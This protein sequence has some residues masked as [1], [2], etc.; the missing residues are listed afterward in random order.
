[1]DT[2]KKR[3]RPLVQ[4]FLAELKLWRSALRLYAQS[5]AN[6]AKK[7]WKNYKTKSARRRQKFLDKKLVALSRGLYFPGFKNILAL[8]RILNKF[9]HRLLEILGAI[10]LISAVLLVTQ[11]WLRVTVEEAGT[12]G[13]YREGL[14]GN[15]RFL[16]PIYLAGNQTDHDISRLL[17]SSLLKTDASGNL[18]QDLAEEV[19]L[20]DGGKKYKITIRKNALFHDGTALGAQDVI[21]TL[22]YIKN[23]EYK[24]PLRPL[25]GG[26][27]AQKLDDYTLTLTLETPNPAFGAFLTF[28][29][30]PEHLWK[31]IKPAET[32][33]AILN[34]KP[35]GSGPYKF[36]SL[37]KDQ[38]GLVRSITVEAFNQY[39]GK[40]PKISLIT[41][42]FFPDEE[43]AIQS[44]KNKEIEALAFFSAEVPRETKRRTD[45]KI[46]RPQTFSYSAFFFNNS[47]SHTGFPEV[48]RALSLAL[49][50]EA[51]YREVIKGSGRLMTG[52]IPPEL[53]S[54]YTEQIPETNL[55][56]ANKILE[57]SGWEQGGEGARI[58]KT[59]PASKKDRGGETLLEI[60]LVTTDDSK[61]MRIAEIAAKSWENIGIKTNLEIVPRGAIVEFLR[62][63][64]YDVLLYGQALAED[65][66]LYPFWHSSGINF[67]GLNLAMFSSREADS[68]LEK[69]RLETDLRNKLPYYRELNKIFQR[70]VP[71]IF[72]WSPRSA[73]VI[74]TKIKGVKIGRVINP[75]DRF[76]AISEWYIKSRRVLK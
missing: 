32:Q 65:L 5:S 26:V 73:Y 68:L 70:E 43:R 44:L 49:N 8:P 13:E 12:G 24:S 20:E 27:S 51:L 72:L 14:V 69:A 15:P 6:Q 18:I 1:M 40:K 36:K 37:R 56:E 50:Y 71:T 52:P 34:I 21:A 42:V 2:L 11:A 39:F 60:H 25:F 75:A 76:A 62:L 28:G 16:N 35:V 10:F 3:L 7:I 38:G 66:D 23:K 53:L 19:K 33:L 48:R 31:N 63:R 9:E 45:V 74:S 54:D 55:E 17:F 29:I 4:V 47:R 22:N 61:N 30:L 41:F 59:K 58:K 46:Y 67:P 57:D 64:N